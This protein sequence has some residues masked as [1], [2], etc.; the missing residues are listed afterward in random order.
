VTC[1][2]HGENCPTPYSCAQE[3]PVQMFDDPMPTLFE[4]FDAA[5]IWVHQHF[6]GI[7][8]FCAAAGFSA[9][10]YFTYFF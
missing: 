10:F 7:V 6:I 4:L 1:K 3:L 9:G 2:T 5:V 8:G